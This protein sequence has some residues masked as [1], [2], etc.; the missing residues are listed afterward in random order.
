MELKVKEAL[1]NMIREGKVKIEN[2]FNGIESSAHQ[3]ATAQ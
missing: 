1:I 2:P 3:I